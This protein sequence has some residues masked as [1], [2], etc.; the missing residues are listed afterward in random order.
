VP[1]FLFCH[2]NDPVCDV[3]SPMDFGPHFTY[4]S[5]PAELLELTVRLRGMAEA[6]TTAPAPPT[7]LAP[8]QRT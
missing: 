6:A 7:A 2:D 1:T 5:A 8:D 4:G 3:T